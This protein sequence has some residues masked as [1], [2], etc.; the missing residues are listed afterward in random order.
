[1]VTA[2]PR[3]TTPTASPVAIQTGT[4]TDVPGI[5]NGQDFTNV[6]GKVIRI[7]PYV[8]NADG[9][10][11]T[12]PADATAKMFGGS[13]RYFIPNSNPFVGNPQNI[14]FT[15][16]GPVGSQTPVAPLA[17]LFAIGFRNPWK[18]SFD[19]NAAPG[20][21]PFVADVGSTQ[22]EE[23]DRVASRRRITAGRTARAISLPARR[24]VD[25]SLPVTCHFLSRRAPACLPSSIW[26]PT[27]SDPT[28]MALPTTRLGTHSG[29][30]G[31]LG[32]LRSAGQR[33]I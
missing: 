32:V 17:E 5:S 31:P 10:P 16:I 13:T 18:L 33:P 2:V 14:F 7:D 8:T 19:K 11:R 4:A 27:L 9:S 28:Q 22:R 25:R 6:L 24:T 1:M 30:L 3:A 23:I 29:S 15:P 20:D 12:T 26:I 21:A